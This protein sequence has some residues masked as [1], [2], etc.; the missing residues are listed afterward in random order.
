ACAGS[1]FCNMYAGDVA[2][3]TRSFPGDGMPIYVVGS[4]QRSGADWDYL[5]TRINPNGTLDTSFGFG[6]ARYIP[7][8]QPGS[9]RGDFAYRLVIDSGLPGLT[10]DTLYV[11]GN[12]HRSC[13][14]G[15]GVAAISDDGND[16]VGFGTNGRIVHGGSSESGTICAQDASLAI[17]DLVRNGNEL[18]MAGTMQGPDQGGTLRVDGGL[19]RVDATN[20][21]QRGLARLPFVV[22]GT[23]V[24]D[25]RLR[26]ISHDRM[27]RYLV[28]GDLS[29]VP[30]GLGSLYVSA[31]VA[32]SDR[33]FANGFDRSVSLP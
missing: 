18:A 21:S 15:I 24:G 14:D 29:N 32:P 8:D 6:G 26:G 33:I 19:L 7:F 22:V 17:G 12:V 16:L 30:F 31:A 11:A 10:F 25:G 5:V 9:D 28:T 23:P 4:V 20:G 1:D 13:K 27:G 2:R 3:P